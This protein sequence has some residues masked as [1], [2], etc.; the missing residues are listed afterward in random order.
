MRPTNSPGTLL[1]D[2]ITSNR[3]SIPVIPPFSALHPLF[4]I[5]RRWQPSTRSS[6][7]SHA[8]KLPLAFLLTSVLAIAD[9]TSPPVRQNQE[10]AG[11]LVVGLKN[12]RAVGE[13]PAEV[14]VDFVMTN[15][16]C[17]PIVLAERWNSWGA[18]QWSFELTDARGH[19]FK[20]GNPQSVW[21][22]NFLST[23]VVPAGKSV[24]FQCRLGWQHGE[25]EDAT[26]CWLFCPGGA[27]PSLATG[28][29][30][31]SRLPNALDAWTYPIE[32]E[33]IFCSPLIHRMKVG[34]ESVETDWT[35]T[36]VTPTVVIE[37]EE[38]DSTGGK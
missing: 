14:E 27:I 15:K 30:T 2:P 4:G 28:W 7:T 10:E 20:L 12:G 9:V 34:D 21:Y 5:S 37:A 18:H 13:S 3:L 6:S 33:G 22:C 24:T 29:G 31:H 8:M 25:T 17:K 11:G 35:G 16:G 1:R 32:L 23:F 26:R 36:L 38:P 19:V